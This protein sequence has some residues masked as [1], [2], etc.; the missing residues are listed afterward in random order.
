MITFKNLLDD[1]ANWSCD[2]WQNIIS[3]NV[4]NFS[5]WIRQPHN[6]NNWQLALLFNSSALLNE[7]L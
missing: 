6:A 3:Q 4:S 5:I 7:I 2:E 1:D